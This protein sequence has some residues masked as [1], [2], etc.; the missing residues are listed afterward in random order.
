M[1]VHIHTHI[2]PAWNHIEHVA[3]I[4]YPTSKQ[5]KRNIVKQKQN[6]LHKQTCGRLRQF[7]SPKEQ[8]LTTAKNLDLL[9]NWASYWL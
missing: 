9:F 6:S 1:H 4:G 2:P 8:T 3:K 5:A 7:T